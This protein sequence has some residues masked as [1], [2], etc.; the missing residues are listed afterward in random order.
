MKQKMLFGFL[1]VLLLFFGCTDFLKELESMP[2]KDFNDYF[3][4]DFFGSDANLFDENFFGKDVNVWDEFIKQGFCPEGQRI[5]EGKCIPIIEC[6]DGTFEPDCSVKKPF[7]CIKEELVENIE[8]CGCPFD[9][10]KDENKCIEIQRCVDDT[11]YRNC[12]S[13]KPV[14]CE[15]G[16]LINKASFCGCPEFNKIN[17]E[18][19]EFD[20]KI[21]SIQRKLDFVLRA[22]KSNFLFSMQSEL[23]KRLAGISRTYYCN[24]GCPTDKELILMYLDE[25]NQKNELLK[26]VELIKIQS[27]EPDDRARIA[28]SLVQRIPYDWT[29]F[30]AERSQERYPFEVVFDYAGVC[31]EKSKLLV[32]LLRE[33]GY[34][35]AIFDFEKENHWAVGIKCPLEY[36]YNNSGYCFIESTTPT[37]IT[38]SKGDYVNIGKLL[39]EPKIIELSTGS[40]FDSVSEEYRDLAELTKLNE[41]KSMNQEEYKKWTEITQKYFLTELEEIVLPAENPQDMTTLIESI[42]TKLS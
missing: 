6:I 35:T 2:T 32:F 31:G 15:Q 24:P 8:L 7:Q 4:S 41:L 30:T 12:G 23:K 20:F 19:C 25:K 17:A 13:A 38:D 26:L 10:R 42:K 22:K 33:L 5:F 27:S 14:F 1:F 36:S 3:D 29:K 40:S 39:S 34:G 18:A 16:K 21:K 28:V 37:I 11:E 9:F